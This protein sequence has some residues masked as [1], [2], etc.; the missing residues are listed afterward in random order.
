MLALMDIKCKFMW[1]DISL[2]GGIGS[3]GSGPGQ[4]ARYSTSHIN[5]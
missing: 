4:M 5:H 3:G 2:L 1:G